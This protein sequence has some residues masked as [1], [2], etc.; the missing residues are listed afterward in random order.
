MPKNLKN[1]LNQLNAE[2]VSVGIDYIN[3]QG[4]KDNVKG[5]LIYYD[6]EMLVI[7]P[8]E[9]EGV[10]ADIYNWKY[11]VSI[12]VYEKSGKNI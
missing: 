2:K 4:F 11:I 5:E 9:F 12:R 10:K 7:H 6:D 1:T 8:T 3:T